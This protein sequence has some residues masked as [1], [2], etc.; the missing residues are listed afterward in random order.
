MKSYLL[1]LIALLGSVVLYGAAYDP[2]AIYLTW[3]K[4]P[5]TTMT[6]GWLSD[7]SHTSDKVEYKRADETLWKPITGKHAPLPENHP[8][9]IHHAEMTCLT[10]D[11]LYCFRMDPEGVVYKFRTMPAQFDKP[12]RFVVGG[13]LYPDQIHWVEKMNRQVARLDPQFIVLGGDLSY[14][15]VKK[16]PPSECRWIDLLIQW[17]KDL[18]TPDGRLIPL[19]STIGNHEVHKSKDGGT[20]ADAPF[21]YA[22]FPNPG[23][24]AL[25]FGNYLSILLLDSGHTHPIAGAQTA[26]LETAL[27]TH[28]Q[29]Q[30]KIAVYHVAA[31]PSVRSFNGHDKQEI[32]KHWVPLFE[33]YGVEIAF[34]HHDHAYKRTHPLLNG[35]VD[36][37]GVLYIGD[38]GWGVEKP[39]KVKNPR[40]IW[41]L[42]KTACSRNIVFVELHKQSRHITAYDE[43]GTRLDDFTF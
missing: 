18:V 21:Y 5:E 10:P 3:Q 19:V 11:T 38:G 35:K 7:L 4:S 20:P 9:L 43:N 15:G 32:R 31:F 12:V 23:Y 41:Y 14:H 22:F 42:A 17:K 30:H 29:F 25:D 16:S 36:L 1:T 27:K 40:R 39:R 34:E 6:V 33:K 28:Q 2:P 24:F 37:H 8:F 26:W 13:D